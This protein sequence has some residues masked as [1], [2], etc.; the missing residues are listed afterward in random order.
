MLRLVALAS[1]LL[2]VSCGGSQ[3]EPAPSVGG[4]EPAVST[5]PAMA[6]D[7]SA[8]GG[9]ARD[10]ER[11]RA[12]EVEPADRSAELDSAIAA[13]PPSPGAPDPTAVYSVPID[14]DPVQGSAEAPVTIV[15]VTQV[16][17][18][19]PYCTRVLPTIEQIRQEYGDRVRVV[20]KQFVVHRDVASRH[21]LAACA[22]HEQGK[23]FEMAGRLYAS[24]LS[25]WHDY[26][27]HGLEIGLDP[28]RLAA[29]LGGDGCVQKILADMERMGQIGVRGVPSFFINGRP[30]T[31]GR[32]I[33]EFRP[34][35]DEELKK[36]EAALRKGGSAASYYE[37][38]VARGKRTAP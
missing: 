20:W 10:A 35:I 30:L 22:A 19:C 27:S 7:M 12:A 32:P 38:I 17:R 18:R 34:L 4:A 26:R 3:T 29:D 21:A 13:L 24:D 8:E 16:H 36:A 14:G 37:G 5:G 15:A 2:A 9:R 11:A 25:T 33:E 23:F 28:E 31:G 6:A 1:L